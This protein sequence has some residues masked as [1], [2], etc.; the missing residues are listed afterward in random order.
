M[1]DAKLIEQIEKLRDEIRRHDRL[2]YVEAMPE[3]SD[4]DYDRLMVELKAL[5]T[6]NPELITPDSPTQ[7]VGGEPIEGFTSVAHAA[8]MLSIDNT[9]NADDLREFD[10]RVRKTLGDAP[11]HYIV[12]PKIDGVAVSLRYEGGVLVLAA[13][14]GDGVRGDDI[15]LNARTIGAIPLKLLGEG[16]PDVLEVRGEVYWPR[17]AFEAYNAERQAEGLERF[18]NPRNGTAGTLKQHD[19]ADVVDRGLAFIAHGLGEWSAM[20]AERASAIM[21]MLG[22]WGVPTGGFWQVCESIE[23]VL[24]AVDAWLIERG[25]VDYETDGMVAKVDELALRDQLGATS[26]YPRWCIAYKYA[27]E[28]AQ[29]VL[30]AVTFDA[31]RTGVITPVASFDPVQLAGTTV[32]NASLHNFDQIERLG[33][34]VGDTI[35][36]QKAG[37]IIPQVV[38]V[39]AELRPAE[40]EELAA[41]SVCPCEKETVLE[42]RAVP[43]GY[44]AFQCTSAEC[45]EYL[46][47]VPR[48]TE[49]DGCRKCGG[50]VR[51]VDHM[52]E[53]LCEADDCPSKLSARIEFFAGRGQMDIENL[54]PAVIEQL[55]VG[56]MVRNFADLYKLTVEP[57]AKLDRMAETSAE[58]LVQA[59]EASKGRGLARLIAAL[60]IRHVGGRAAEVL[61]ARFGDMDAIAAAEIDE[62]TALEEIGPTIAGSVREF[63]D[64]AER[65]DMLAEMTSLGVKMRAQAG[66]GGKT[67]TLAGR[68]VVI[69]G[70]LDGWS[71]RDAQEAVK[72][73]GGKVSSSVSK[74]T[75]FVV[76]GDSPG[77]KAAKARELGV[78]IIDAAELKRRLTRE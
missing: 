27:A 1:A 40:A 67:G 24:A 41:P 28:R 48:K 72:S 25:S 63:F 12:D 13:T 2:Y 4:R 26:K 37:E 62:L 65:R 30:R 19:P 31:G 70:V 76:V 39:V 78:E 50:A 68:T 56:G 16:W 22:E 23:G 46:Q 75:D 54:G 77:S 47:R 7:R 43:E 42:W 53:L 74:K 60:G 29:T 11:F 61:A 66:S 55:V 20:P 33:V 32:S 64:S 9:Y 3:I 57:L 21:Q 18:A 6:A 10:K 5:E 73:A 34:R 49:P 38:G 71:R 17:S 15:T 35:I 45:D 69:T 44:R 52:A 36:V 58:N 59:I 51:E 14:R 8:P